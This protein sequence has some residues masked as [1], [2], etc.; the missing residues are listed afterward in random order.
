MGPG[1]TNGAP[2]DHANQARNSSSQ[3]KK[4]G[5]PK[6]PACNAASVFEGIAM[7]D[8]APAPVE[9]GGQALE[10]AASHAALDAEDQRSFSTRRIV[11]TH[12]RSKWKVLGADGRPFSLGR[13]RSD[14]GS[15]SERRPE[16]QVGPPDGRVP[17]GSSPGNG[18]GLKTYRPDGTV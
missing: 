8:V 14:A 5:T 3:A 16:R 18:R 15:G 11:G 2:G 13:R 9:L 1:F 17:R 10:V 4:L 7:G 12:S 6:A